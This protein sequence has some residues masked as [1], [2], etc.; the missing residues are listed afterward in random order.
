MG[1]LGEF[2]NKIGLVDYKR[3]NEETKKYL[4]KFGSKIKPT[5]RVGDLKVADQQVIEII[6]SISL[7]S[8]IIIFDEPTSSLT[9]TES[10]TLFEMIRNLKIKGI[11]ILYI[12]HRME[13]IFRLCD[14]IIILRD[15]ELI[16]TLNTKD[17]NTE[18][19][20]RNMVGRTITSF[21]PNKSE[22]IGNVIFEGQELSC[23]GIFKDISFQLHKGEVLGFSG[24]VGAGRT[25]LMR[26]LCGIYKLSSGIIKLH[27]KK[28]KIDNYAESIK[29]GIVY[30]TEIENHKV[31]F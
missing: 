30:L 5:E 15:G 2:T 27:G 6:K 23:E 4:D 19:V 20:V 22:E 3:L 21:Y 31:Y 16:D 11:S 26:A 12:S 28:I 24:L 1:R 8:K 18:E 14:R 25:E 9:K 10:K 17:T 13:E 29:Q 7:D